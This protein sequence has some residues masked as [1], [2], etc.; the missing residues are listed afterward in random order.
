MNT[1]T[2]WLARTESHTLDKSDWYR[3]TWDDE[4]DR[5]EWRYAGTPRFP[6]LILRNY[7]GALCGYVGVAPGHPYHGKQWGDVDVSAHGGA[8]YSDACDEE[9]GICHVPRAG[10]SPEVWWI[11]FD[12]SHHG[13]Y[14]YMRAKSFDRPPGYWP[15]LSY[16]DVDYVR[17]EVESLAA[18]LSR[19]AKG[20]P[21]TEE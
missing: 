14:S 3:G 8:T 6:L 11:G 2:E 13:D 9:S 20:L 15:E 18:Q 5:I 10:E 21:A 19:V 12:C 16:C 7:A 1:A 17:A 4:P